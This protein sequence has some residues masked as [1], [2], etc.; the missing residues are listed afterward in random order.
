MTC[1]YVGAEY[2]GHSDPLEET[3]GLHN[4]SKSKFSSV[5]NSNNLL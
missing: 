4:M 5:S 2:V 1:D 3:G